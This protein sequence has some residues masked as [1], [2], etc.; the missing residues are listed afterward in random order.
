MATVEV[1]TIYV[2]CSNTVFTGRNTGIQRVVRN[3]VKRIPAN[4]SSLNVT[5]MP[6][7]AVAGDFY[8]FDSDCG[9]RFS[10]SQTLLR[11]IGAC[12]N[13]LNLLFSNKCPSGEWPVDRIHSQVGN[14][15]LHGR[16]VGTSRRIIPY[17][18]KSAYR[19]DGILGEKIAFAPNDVLF[20][21]DVFWNDS[22]VDSIS[23]VPRDTQVTLL[24]YDLISITHPEVFTS[25]SSDNFESSLLNILDRV[26]AILSISKTSLSAIESYVA[27]RKAGIR[28]DHFYLGADFSTKSGIAGEVRPELA[29][30]FDSGMTYLAVG[31]IEP[32]KNYRYLLSAFER[33]WQR[34]SDVKL[35]IVGRLGWKCDDVVQRI[36]DSPELGSRLFHYHDLNDCEL[37]YCYSN[38]KAIVFSSIDEGF[39]LPFVEA[40]H[41]GKPVFASDIPVFREVGT[42]YPFYFDLAD[43]SSLVQRVE[44]FATSC[45][46]KSFVPRQWLSWDQSVRDLFEKVIFMAQKQAG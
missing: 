32:R 41:Y 10:R 35:C 25:A 8:R 26:D 45:Y 7:V 38:C 44:A 20:L 28:Y 46:E 12:R 43:P 37:E 27:Q 17:V 21:A 19:A 40:M 11:F 29:G 42:D 33:L 6:V 18:F 34:G 36:K 22:M 39:G 30:V 5:I 13:T 31:T 1:G 9:K 2:D 16:I 3:V 15:D 14:K 24:I 23:R 4:S